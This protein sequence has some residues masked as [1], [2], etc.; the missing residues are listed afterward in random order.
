MFVRQTLLRTPAR[1]LTSPSQLRTISSTTAANLKIAGTE[2]LTD[3]ASGDKNGGARPF[4]VQ[5]SNRLNDELQK[6]GDT[7]K[8][9]SD[10]KSSI[11][12]YRGR[13]NADRRLQSSNSLTSLISQLLRESISSS[14][15]SKL[16]P[17]EI[18]N[19]ICDSNLARPQHFKIVMEYFLSEGRIRDVMSLWVKY[20]MLITQNPSLVASRASVVGGPLNPHTGIVALTTVAYLALPDN[21][22][23]IETL[24]ELL[25]FKDTPTGKDQLPIK[26]VGVFVHQK[27]PENERAMT[28]KNYSILF[29]QFINK[30]PEWLNREITNAYDLKTLLGLYDP[31]REAI[32]FAS[33]VSFSPEVIVQFTDKF[34]GIGRPEVAIRVYNDFKPVFKEDK[35]AMGLLNGHLLETVSRL[36]ATT[37][38]YR[39]KRVQAVWN[40]LFKGTEP[41]SKEAYA[42]LLK[43]LSLCQNSGELQE[44]WET[45]IPDEVRTERCVKEAYFEALL[46]TSRKVTVQEIQQQLPDKIGSLD[47]LNAILRNLVRQKEFDF[48]LFEEYY[49]KFF[50]STPQI[51]GDDSAPRIRIKPNAE[52]FGIRMLALYLSHQDKGTGQFEFLKSIGVDKDRNFGKVLAIIENFVTASPSVEPVRQLYEELKKS[53]D[54]RLYKIFIEAEFIKKGGSSAHAEAL[55]EEYI[56]TAGVSSGTANKSEIRA[57]FL[58]E[59]LDTLMAGFCALARKEQNTVYIRKL[60]EYSAVYAEINTKP[61]VTTLSKILSTLSYLSAQRSTEINSNDKQFIEEFLQKLSHDS[62]RANQQDLRKL[63]NNGIEVPSALIHTKSNA[64]DSPAEPNVSQEEDSAVEVVT[65]GEHHKLRD[66]Q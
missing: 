57:L 31:I 50:E 64:T 59:V 5:L 4:L 62:F 51:D 54:S 34:N 45:E 29:N 3:S 23:D 8:V 47:L 12:E 18:L 58:K 7:N 6:T 20:L 52:T 21:T 66:E 17:Y 36:P 28:S 48:K 27:I 30:N 24:Y 13:D 55:L 22:P 56:T 32:S 39:L 40:T 38:E 49:S 10:F 33:A 15:D 42:S 14:S 16:E 60:R 53:A 19:N 26:L 41:V 61:S 44:F 43:S 2:S 46:R 25:Q 11:L 37:R 9:Y 63:K 35:V 65:E 1:L